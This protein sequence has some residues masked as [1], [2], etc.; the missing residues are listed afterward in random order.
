MTQADRDVLADRALRQLQQ[1]AQA[2]A[3]Q[4]VQET[5]G[6]DSG[7]ASDQE[8]ATPIQAPQISD[9]ELLELAAMRTVTATSF[10]TDTAM[11]ESARLVTCREIIDVEEDAQ[12][13]VRL[14]L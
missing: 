6:E 13:R 14:S 4:A 5:T 2:A 8:V 7:Q 11:I 10:L 9:G 3:A 12:P 1:D